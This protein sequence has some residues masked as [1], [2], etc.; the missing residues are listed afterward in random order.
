M[1]VL[2]ALRSAV[3]LLLIVLTLLP[4]AIAAGLAGEGP[5]AERIV[6]LWCRIV[7]FCAGARLVVRELTPLD[8]AKSYVFVANHTSHLDVP[9]IV[10]SSPVP[11]RFIAKKEL[12][13]IPL[14]GWA[15]ERIGHVFVDRRESHAATRAIARRIERGLTGIGLLFFAEGT[16]SMTEELLPFKK[17]AAVAAL[18][19]GLDCVPVGIAGAR[20]VLAPKGPPLFRPGTIALVFGPPIPIAGHTLDERDDLVLLQRRGVEEA[21]GVAR[22]LLSRGPAGSGT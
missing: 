7:L 16:R 9:A 14:F 19:T 15:A 4:L 22:S 17:G 21:V 5:F 2:R 10:R 3:G 12:R 1:I 20:D 8:P 18:Q 13:R 11:P 6:R